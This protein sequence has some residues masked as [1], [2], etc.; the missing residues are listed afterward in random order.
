MQ[1]YELRK[2][3]SEFLKVFTHVTEVVWWTAVSPAGRDLWTGNK[4]EKRDLL[5]H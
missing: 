3:E 5:W 1:F 4:Y 2:D